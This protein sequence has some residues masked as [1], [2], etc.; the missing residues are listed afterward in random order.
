MV[1]RVGAPSAL[2]FTPVSSGMLTEQCM[3]CTGHFGFE[4]GTT[5]D[6][7]VTVASAPLHLPLSFTLSLCE[8]DLNISTLQKVPRLNGN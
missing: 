3:S 7:C 8:P 5:C 1:R 4:F 2:T 6:W